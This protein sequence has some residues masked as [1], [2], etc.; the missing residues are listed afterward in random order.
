VSGAPVRVEIEGAEEVARRFGVLSRQVDDLHSPFANVAAKIATDGRSFAPKVTGRLAAG[1]IGSATRRGGGATIYGVPYAGVINFGW[2][3]R[4]IAAR[5]F[6]QRAAD[7]KGEDAAD[8]VAGEIQ[9]DIDK[10]G[11][12]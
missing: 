8:Q 6:M 7:S 12:G 10:D 1:I 9:R 5:L 2:R 4:G 11:L 3:H